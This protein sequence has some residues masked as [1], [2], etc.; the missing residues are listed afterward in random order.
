[1]WLLLDNNDGDLHGT[2][3]DNGYTHRHNYHC[4]WHE[5]SML[6]LSSIFYVFFVHHGK[7]HCRFNSAWFCKTYCFLATE[8]HVCEQ[9]AHGY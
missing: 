5:I 8:A 2:S 6:L 4:D 9:T 7:G 3:T 1:M